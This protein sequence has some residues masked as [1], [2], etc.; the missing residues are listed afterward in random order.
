[1]STNQEAF[2]TYRPRMYGIAY[3]MLGSKADAEDVVQDAWLRWHE[4][5]HDQIRSAEAGLTTTVTRLAIDRLR[6]LK[7]KKETYVGPWLP[8]PL[9]EIAPYTPESHAEF[10]SDVSI[11]FLTLLE[12]LAPEE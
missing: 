4:Q 12:R 6:A 11:A 9:G 1:M 8:E 7:A 10:A 2:L 5:Q 3:R